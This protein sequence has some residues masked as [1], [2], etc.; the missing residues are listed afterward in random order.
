M[1]SFRAGNLEILANAIESPPGL[2]F[3]WR[4][5]SSDRT[6]GVLLRPYFAAALDEAVA[7][8]LQIELRFHELEHFNS[9]TVSAVIDLIQDAAARQVRLILGYDGRVKWQRLSFDALRVFCRPDGLLTLA[10]E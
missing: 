7:R 9:A 2:G 3:T 5:R 8:G 1:E 4:G 6:P 10:G